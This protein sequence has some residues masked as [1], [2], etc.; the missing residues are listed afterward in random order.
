VAF[1]QP[2]TAAEKPAAGEQNGKPQPPATE[3]KTESTP[4]APADDAANFEPLE[5]VKDDIR[6]RLARQE[7]DKR[8]DAIFSAI[9]TDMSRYAEDFA[10]WQASGKDAGAAAPTPPNFEKIAATLGQTG[11]GR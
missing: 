9:A 11:H 8:I 4:A 2:D 1:R 10:L 3:Q 6:Q 7:A 5:K